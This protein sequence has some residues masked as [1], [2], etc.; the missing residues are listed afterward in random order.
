M[1]SNDNSKY[2]ISE[3]K[4]NSIV[5]DAISNGRYIRIVDYENACNFFERAKKDYKKATFYT[6]FENVKRYS[7]KEGY[8]TISDDVYYICLDEVG[9]RNFAMLIVCRIGSL[10][11]KI[12]YYR[13][14]LFKSGEGPEKLDV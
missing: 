9:K 5:N 6:V 14:L 13:N 8:Q 11:D 7:E 10:A 1:R 3:Q 4:Y 12:A 2:G